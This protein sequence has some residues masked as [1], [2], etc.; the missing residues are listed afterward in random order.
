MRREVVITEEDKP[1]IERVLGIMNGLVKKVGPDYRYQKFIKDNR[2]ALPACWY[3][4][5]DENPSCIVGHV[6]IE[7]GFTKEELEE[8]E[9]STP[10]TGILNMYKEV[11]L[12]A[13][14]IWKRLRQ[15]T[16]HILQSVQTEQDHNYT[17]KEA[18]ERGYKTYKRE[19]VMTKD[20]A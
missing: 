1:E 13:V 17:W 2:T 8:L 14:P 5:N 9:G 15:A 19:Y 16:L 11:H 12:K 18:V 4:D 3:L 10:F 20:N 7:L 6:L